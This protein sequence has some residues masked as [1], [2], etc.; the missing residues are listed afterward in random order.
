M[1][2]RRGV[3][4]LLWALSSVGGGC[5]S[6][7][8]SLPPTASESGGA[9]GASATGGRDGGTSSVEPSPSATPAPS[10]PSTGGNGGQ[11]FLAREDDWELTP[12][13][14]VCRTRV[15]R[16]PKR[17][18]PG[19][20]WQDC[21]TGCRNSPVSLGPRTA[22]GDPLGVASRQRGDELLVSLTFRSPGRLFV[23]GAF[24][25]GDGGAELLV[26]VEGDDCLAQVAGNR[27]PRLFSVL[28][29]GD[30]TEVRF[31]WIDLESNPKLEWLPQFTLAELFYT[32]GSIF[33][34]DTGWGNLPDLSAVQLTRN[35]SAIALDEVYR[36]SNLVHKAVGD[37][38]SVFFNE[39][40]T[41]E[42]KILAI[43][44]DDEVVT[45]ASGDWFPAG[46]GVSAD[47]VVWIG[48]HGERVT[49]GA[50]ESAKL[51]ACERSSTPGPCESVELVAELPITATDGMVV[52]NG[53]WVAFRGCQAEVCDVYLVRLDGGQVS[54]LRRPAGVDRQRVIGIS[55]SELF[56]LGFDG[57]H[58]SDEFSSLQRYTLADIAENA[59][60][61]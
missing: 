1:L 6:K 22:T 47:R 38:G 46:T 14:D 19:F 50:L 3:A 4:L 52:T 36:S 49:D 43:T 42:G 58:R 56:V 29:L 26:A 15:A 44:P 39:G 12:T 55:K 37:S 30:P 24:D 35:P 34:F 13:F 32:V 28:K 7:K 20:Q 27:S 57:E 41:G 16:D 25:F 11:D 54:R 51:Y 45:I 40:W 5:G 2:S 48:A 9:A 59:T 8:S 31:G 21:G 53:S 17:S 60:P 10:I 18:W 33:D 23:M 61:L